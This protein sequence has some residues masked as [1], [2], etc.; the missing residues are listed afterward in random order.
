MHRVA[1]QD[2]RFQLLVGGEQDGAAGGLVNAV[3]FHPHQAAFD[4]VDP[5]DAVLAAQ[6]VQHGYDG[7]RRELLA[8][9]CHRGAGFE[10]DL[11]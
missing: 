8:V 9:D 11:I 4:H 6:L 3:R 5:A 7:C 1:V 2:D 10:G